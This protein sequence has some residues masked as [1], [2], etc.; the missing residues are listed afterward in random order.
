MR[1][2]RDARFGLLFFLV[3]LTGALHQ[4]AAAEPVVGESV[5]AR[6]AE[7][8]RVRVIVFLASPAVN[9]TDLDRLA[10]VVSRA[11][12]GVLQA[13]APDD[14]VLE[15]RF[16]MI[17]ALAGTITA[18]GVEKLAARPGVIRV[19]V[20]EGGKGTLLEAVPLTNANAVQALGYTGQ[21]VTVAVLDSGLDTDHP[22]LGDDLV[23]EA[24]FCRGDMG[25][26]PNGNDVQLGAGAAEDDNGHGSNVTG[27]VT[28]KG[29][30][31]PL[32]VAPDAGIAAIKV[33]A[34][35]NTFCCNADV[36][37]GLD[38][39]IMDLPDV[40]VVN[41]SLGT[42]DLYNGNCDNANT[43]T[44]A[45]AEAI[46]TL[47]ANGVLTFVSS[48][49]NGSGTQMNAPAC[50][51][52]AIS[53]GAVW[54]DDVGSQVFFCSE[55]TTAADKVTCFT[56]TNGATDIFAPGA[57][58]TSTWLSGLT[59]T[60][61]GTS[62][63]SPHAAGCAADFL[64][65]DAS[66]TPT[67]IELTLE[68]TG[69]LVTDTTNGLSFPRVDCL[70]ALRGLT[71]AAGRV[72]DDSLTVTDAGGGDITLTWSASCL[73]TD[74]DYGIYEGTVGSYASHMAKFCSTGGATAWTFTPAAESRYYL[75][76]PQKALVEGSYGTD[77]TGAERPAAAM[78][79]LPQDL[80]SCR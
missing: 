28:S 46:N 34:S 23:H 25:C 27:I 79:C 8:P 44:M 66:L 9:P 11:Q 24:C 62:Q 73:P 56:N 20:D 21:G 80:V 67:E 43:T 39:I 57:P 71:T 13:L 45:Y 3:F 14:F 51:Q 42:F 58:I 55:P 18:S 38:H 70:A 15:R 12:E 29:M 50:I 2:A 78:S 5:H 49:N 72:T 63:A 74:T 26:C 68:S 1:A 35:D 19:D 77:S 16:Q 32:G 37:A 59:Q 53:V 48:G 47:R 31:A 54:D 6:L 61:Y 60:Y 36:L 64:E 41:M 40:D 52:N 33:L 17:P 30:V 76:V 22:D 69:K 10:R 4:T 75:V 65:A 7:R